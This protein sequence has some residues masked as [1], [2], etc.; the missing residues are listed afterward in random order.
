[1]KLTTTKNKCIEEVGNQACYLFDLGFYD[2]S[3]KL[4][5]CLA[6]ENDSGSLNQ[7]GIIYLGGYGVRKNKKKALL[8]FKKAARLKESSAMFNIA[9]FYRYDVKMYR[10][11]LHRFRLLEK[12]KKSGFQGEA[13]LE[14]AMMYH[15]GLGVKKDDEKAKTMLKKLINR[16]SIF[17]WMCEADQERAVDLLNSISKPE[18]VRANKAESPRNPPYK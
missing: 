17:N 7:L 6:E 18:S 12:G 1:M 9:H 15:Q 14:L 3:R 13:I 16:P 10:K 4:F 2:L 8:F 11:A 5:S